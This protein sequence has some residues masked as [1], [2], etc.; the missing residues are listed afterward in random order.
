MRILQSLGFMHRENEGRAEVLACRRFVLVSQNHDRMLHRRP[1]VRIQF[2]QRGLARRQQ[3]HLAFIRR[4]ALNQEV[5]LAID[6]AES[7]LL[8]LQQAVGQRGH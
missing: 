7:G 6:R 5:A 1:G 3:P 2:A 8:D 4:G